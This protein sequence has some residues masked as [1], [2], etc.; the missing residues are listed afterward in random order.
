MATDRNS[1]IG[2]IRNP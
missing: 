1:E 2:A